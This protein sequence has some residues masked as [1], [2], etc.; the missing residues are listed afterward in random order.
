MGSVRIR[1]VA[2]PV[3]KQ[4]HTLFP[5]PSPFY[6][7]SLASSDAGLVEVSSCALLV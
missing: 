5:S 3:R 2:P 4:T 1:T 7:S 6:R